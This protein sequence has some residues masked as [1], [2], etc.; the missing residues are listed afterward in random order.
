MVER[1][2]DESEALEE[3]AGLVLDRPQPEDLVR[4]RE[5][6]PVRVR[7]RVHSAG[8]TLTLDDDSARRSFPYPDAA[9][10]YRLAETSE[11]RGPRGWAAIPFTPAE[12]LASGRSRRDARVGWLALPRGPVAKDISQEVDEHPNLVRRM[13]RVAVPGRPT[14]P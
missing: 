12:R 6:N 10:R 14:A 13:G 1:L 3:G 5:A 8:S 2:V 4:A 7:C 9:R 11:R